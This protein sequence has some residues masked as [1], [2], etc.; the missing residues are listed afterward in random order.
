MLTL[1]SIPY[2]ERKWI[3]VDSGKFSHGC[4]EMSK[5]MIRLVRHDDAVHREGDGAVR[6]DDLA[7]KFKAKFADTSHWSIEAWITFLAKGGGRRK[8]FS[9]LEPE[10][11]RQFLYFRAIQGHSGCALV[12]YVARQCTVA[13]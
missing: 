10:F 3:D 13:G 5:L 12:A 1:V 6:F 7:E 8:G 11:C 9:T 4:F 2:H